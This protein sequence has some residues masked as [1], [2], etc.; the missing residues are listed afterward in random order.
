[1]RV[2]ELERSDLPARHRDA[3]LR[4]VTHEAPALLQGDHRLTHCDLA[5]NHIYLS[6][7]TG[8]WRVSGILD[9]ADA[10]VGPFEWDVAYVWNFAFRYRDAAGVDRE[11]RE[12]MAVWL[13]GAFG[14]DA[15]P[16]RFARRCF[17]ALVHTPSM[18]LLWPW[19]LEAVQ[20][21]PDV[22][23]AATRV[24]FPEAIFGPPD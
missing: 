7:A 11:D 19:V 14:G 16:D 21:E 6:N 20:G 5:H 12:A 3:L 4:F 24:L 15:R 9:W 10:V 13:M 2:R 17:A 18:G 8:A 23:D 22:V 1:M